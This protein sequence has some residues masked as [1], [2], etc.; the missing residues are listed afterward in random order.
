[1]TVRDE[2]IPGYLETPL[3]GYLE[4]VSRYTWARLLK[5]SLISK[6]LDSVLYVGFQQF[7]ELMFL[8]LC[9]VLV[10]VN[11]YSSL[12]RYNNRNYLVMIVHSLSLVEA[13]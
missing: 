13:P 11:H 9:P 8:N 2:A 10:P 12:S 4:G 7:I 1:M 3:E 6:A 5:V